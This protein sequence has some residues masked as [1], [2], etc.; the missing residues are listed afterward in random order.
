[1]EVEVKTLSKVAIVFTALLVGACAS[2]E[3]K[4]YALYGSFVIFEEQGAKLIQSPEVPNSVK[5]KIQEADKVAKPAADGLKS[6]ADSVITAKRQLAA[7][8]TDK[9]KVRI[10]VAN[11]SSWYY[12]VKP[13]I[14]CLI[15]AV[16]EKPCSN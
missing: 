15:R 9:E 2:L 4:S 8:T 16:E 13:K 10:A 3:R 5:L 6:A 7:G 14:E 12:D 11:L 1:L